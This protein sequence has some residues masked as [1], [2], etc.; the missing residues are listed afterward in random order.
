MV[1]VTSNQAVDTYI[2]LAKPIFYLPRFAI[3]MLVPL[4]EVTARSGVIGASLALLCLLGVPFGFLFLVLAFFGDAQPSPFM[5]WLLE[6]AG[7]APLYFGV[8]SAVNN[9][10]LILATK[11]YRERISSL[12]KLS[13]PMATVKLNSS[14]PIVVEAGPTVRPKSDSGLK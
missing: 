5:E 7:V 1:V 8:H 6:L 4:F 13:G 10:I 2:S 12:L 11:P 9:L 3:K 14:G